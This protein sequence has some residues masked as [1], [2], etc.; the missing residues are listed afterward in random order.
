MLAIHDVK[1]SAV[2][3]LFALEMRYGFAIDAPDAS[4]TGRITD[5]RHLTA[6]RVGCEWKI[7]SYLGLN[8]TGPVIQRAHGALIADYRPERPS[9]PRVSLY[10]YDP[11]ARRSNPANGQ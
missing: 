9:D 4:T 3:K 10:T 5:C 8:Y 2:P 7:R 6:R 1:A 11:A